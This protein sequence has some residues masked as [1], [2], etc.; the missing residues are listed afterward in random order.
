MTKRQQQHWSAFCREVYQFTAQIPAGKVCT[1]GLIA[2]ALGAPGHARQVGTALRDV[3]DNLYL[4][5]WR[6]VNA[7]GRTAP[8]WPEQREM[9]EMEGVRFKN[10]GLVDMDAFLWNPCGDD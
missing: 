7:Q 6:V 9:L 5:A 4:P 2:R 1:Y 8:G 3:T 10:N